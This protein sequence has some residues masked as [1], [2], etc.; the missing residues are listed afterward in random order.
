MPDCTAPDRSIAVSV[1]VPARNEE[2]NIGQVIEKSIRTLESRGVVGEVVVINDGS[3]DGTLAEARVTRGGDRGQRRQ[4]STRRGLT[5]ALRTASAMHGRVIIFLPGDMNRSEG[6]P[7]A[8]DKMAEGT[9]VAGWGR[10]GATV[11]CPLRASTNHLRC[12]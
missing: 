3:T 2:G 6:N 5:E 12:C 4:S 7:Q 8:V 1:L 10:G 9:C 11:K